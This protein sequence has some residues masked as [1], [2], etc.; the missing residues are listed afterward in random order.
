MD[1]KKLDAFLDESPF[2]WWEWR[3]PENRVIFNDIKA[4]MLGYDPANF[5]KAGYEAFTTLIHPDDYEKTMDAMR[6]VLYGKARLYQIDYR[7]RAASG[8]YHW[9][10]D[11]GFVL[12]RDGQGNPEIIRGIVI[13]LGQESRFS[14]SIEAIISIVKNSLSPEEATDESFLTV[15]SNCKRVKV[16]E[17]N[18]TAISPE[19]HKFL[20]EKVS[21]GICPDCIRILYPDFAPRILANEG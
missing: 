2:A 9:F 10:M 20:G 3:V 19:L 12:K 21:H 15:C 8:E 11:R 4:T 18:F 5:A 17:R 6:D 1:I 7:I 14:G 13:D 16:G